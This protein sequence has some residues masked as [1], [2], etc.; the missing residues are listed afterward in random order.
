MLQL[1][2]TKKKIYEIEKELRQANEHIQF[3]TQ[4]GDEKQ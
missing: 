2:E 4:I 1:H 3:L